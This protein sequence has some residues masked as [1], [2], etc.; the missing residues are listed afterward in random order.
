MNHI[1][2]ETLALFKKAVKEFVSINQSNLKKDKGSF[3]VAISK[4]KE[5]MLT[6]DLYNNLNTA[7]LSTDGV[8]PTDVIRELGY[9]VERSSSN[10]SMHEK[11]INAFFE[12]CDYKSNNG[13]KYHGKAMLNWMLSN[14]GTLFGEAVTIKNGWERYGGVTKLEFMHDNK[15]KFRDLIPPHTPD[16]TKDKIKSAVKEKYNNLKPNS[17]SL[18]SMITKNNHVYL[19]KL[20]NGLYKFSESSDRYPARIKQQKIEADHC[21]IPLVAFVQLKSKAVE[22]EIHQYLKAKDYRSPKSKF[23]DQFWLE[24]DDV[25]R[26]VFKSALQEKSIHHELKSD[27]SIY[28]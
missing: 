21:F 9:I 18:Q 2:Q 5:W 4:I 23:K 13:I 27:S 25:A 11:R 15:I 3:V 20:K 19:I 12:W 6:H 22:K 14:H 10:D 28:N 26:Q 16:I 8:V 17:K 7:K 1:K 24:N